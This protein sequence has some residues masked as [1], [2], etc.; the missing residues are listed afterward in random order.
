MY[1]SRALI[2]KKEEWGEADWRVSALTADFGK[3]RLL[4]Q[5]VRKHGAKLQGHLEAGAISE[6]SFVIGRN[7][8][9]LTTARLA[10]FPLGSRGSPLKLS[11]LAGMLGT[12]D[13]NLLEERD[14]ARELFGTAETALAVLE[15]ADDDA[16]LRRLAVWFQVRFLSFLGVFPSPR[17]P[18]ARS[19][20]RLLELQYHPPAALSGEGFDP[21]E[22]EREFAWLAQRLGRAFS[23]VGFVPAVR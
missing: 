14:R 11:L 15:A 1:H 18:E 22:L 23:P 6:I 4:A 5:G 2:L 19:V 7:G 12:I 3:I 9:R 17:S 8:Y 21:A 13:A 10:A 16:T 20:P